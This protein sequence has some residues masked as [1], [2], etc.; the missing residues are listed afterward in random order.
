MNV[1]YYQNSSAPLWASVAVNHQQYAAFTFLLIYFSSLYII[2]YSFVTATQGASNILR[3]MRL[4]T[5]NPRVVV[6]LSLACLSLA[7]VPPLGGFFTKFILC[8]ITFTKYNI[9]TSLLLYSLILVS[10]FFYLQIIKLA[11]RSLLLDKED[12][13]EFNDAATS[14]HK[15]RGYI[16]EFANCAILFFLLFFIFFLHDATLLFVDIS[17]LV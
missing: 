12:I 9:L 15:Q 5:T 1:N 11:R 8:Y 4:S 10:F 3:A 6:A 2:C 17:H 16:L 13:R 7:G 14:D